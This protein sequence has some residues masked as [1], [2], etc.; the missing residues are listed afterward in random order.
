MQRLSEALETSQRLNPTDTV[1]DDAN[2]A[3]YQFTI[4]KDVFGTTAK[5]RLCS[6]CAHEMNIGDEVRRLVMIVEGEFLTEHVCRNC[7][8]TYR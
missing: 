7:F 5:N 4:L 8:S 2:D 6:R 3:P 1:A